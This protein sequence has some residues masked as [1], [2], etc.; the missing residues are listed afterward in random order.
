MEG[1]EGEEWAEV[2]ERGEGRGGEGGGERR[3]KGEGE[4]L[5]NSWRHGRH[6]FAAVL[7]N[8][9]CA[10]RGG[11]RSTGVISLVFA[12]PPFTPLSPSLPHSRSLSEV[13]LGQTWER[14]GVGGVKAAGT[15]AGLSCQPTARAGSGGVGGACCT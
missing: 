7:W 4:F 10:A 14:T 12:L 9:G 3:K 11:T 6:N 5:A 15:G 13:P 2:I 1:E 8:L